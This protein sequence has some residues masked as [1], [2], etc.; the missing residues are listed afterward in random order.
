VGTPPKIPLDGLVTVG[1]PDGLV[2]VEASANPIH[3]VVAH[4]VRVTKKSAAYIMRRRL[5]LMN[6]P[7]RKETGNAARLNPAFSG[8]KSYRIV[9]VSSLI[10]M[11]PE[12]AN[13]QIII[14]KLPQL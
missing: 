10:L 9:T 5:N 2:A 7:A 1:V 11:T 4:I 14:P 3:A 6:P 8:V 12:L 13:P